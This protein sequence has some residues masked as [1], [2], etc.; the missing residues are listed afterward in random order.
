MIQD[1]LYHRK[2]TLTIKVNKLV[3]HEDKIYKIRLT[4]EGL[5]PVRLYSSIHAHKFNICE[6]SHFLK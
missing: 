3:M 2:V 1:A 4:R 5:V 6:Q